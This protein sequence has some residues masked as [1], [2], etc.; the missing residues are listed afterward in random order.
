MADR[1]A[2]AAGDEVVL[3]SGGIF[4]VANGKRRG[5]LLPVRIN[6]ATVRRF[7]VV[8]DDDSLRLTLVAY[9]LREEQFFAAAAA[10]AI[11]PIRQAVSASPNTSTAGRRAELV[12]V[13]A[14]AGAQRARHGELPSVAL[15]SIVATLAAAPPTSA[16]DTS[17]PQDR[18][19]GRDRRSRADRR[20]GAKRFFRRRRRRE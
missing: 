12:P 7:A 10:L 19:S 8:Y 16:V 11:D 14:Q 5:L 18:P 17:S 13:A 2:S 1:V 15:G 3:E 9:R 6:G 4:S 20:S